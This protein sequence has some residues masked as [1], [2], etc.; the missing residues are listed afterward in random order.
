MFFCHLTRVSQADHLH[1]VNGLRGR[2]SERAR[3]LLTAIGRTNS[4]FVSSRFVSYFMFC[5]SSIQHFCLVCLPGPRYLFRG[6]RY[7]R[8]Q[9]F[10]S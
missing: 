7:F 10:W 3:Q 4:R 6:R 2:V 1:G 9:L 8:N 5:F